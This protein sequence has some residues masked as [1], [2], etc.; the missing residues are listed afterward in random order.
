MSCKIPLLQERFST[1]R[2]RSVFGFVGIFLFIVHRQ[3]VPI[4]VLFLIGFIVTLFTLKQSCC[5]FLWFMHSHVIVV[6]CVTDIDDM[7]H[8]AREGSFVMSSCLVDDKFDFLC[9]SLCTLIA[10]EVHLVQMFDDD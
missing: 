2:T 10:K 9:K 4:Q 7:T 8:F 6:V 5:F 1:V 3:N